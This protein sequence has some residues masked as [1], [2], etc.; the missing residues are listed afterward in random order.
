MFYFIGTCGK[1]FFGPCYKI[2]CEGF[3][4]GRRFGGK[5]ANAR[6]DLIDYS[7][8]ENHKI[9]LLPTGKKD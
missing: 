3:G 2:R 8:R 6:G 7:H 1:P 9:R 4:E 5:A